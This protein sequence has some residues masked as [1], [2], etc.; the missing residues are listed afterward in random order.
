[1]TTVP[2]SAIESL[3]DV[4][5]GAPTADNM[6]PLCFRWDGE[7]LAVCYDRERVAG[8]TFSPSAPAT[9]LALGCVRE[10]VEVTATMRGLEPHWEPSAGLPDEDLVYGY[11]Y[12]ASPPA[13]GGDDSAPSRHTNR[14]PYSGKQI[15]ATLLSGIGDLVE[16]QARVVVFTDR[17]SIERVARCVRRASELRFRIREVHEWLAHSLRFSRASADAGDGL[18]VKTLGLPP[19]GPGFLRL[20]S[21]WN[22]MRALNAVG[23]YKLV[24]AIDSAPVKAA[25][26][27]VAVIGRTDPPG[28]CDAG[29][30]LH[31]A[32]CALNDGGLA[33]HPYYVI[34]DQLNRHRDGGIPEQLEGAARS[35]ADEAGALFGLGEGET[36][37]MLFRTGWPKRAAV[38]SQR[39]PLSRILSR[40]PPG[41]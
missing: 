3:V 21:D 8:H 38:R 41:G 39:L 23:G 15:P 24:S 5:R 37:H 25:P 1:M 18:D 17:S 12:F 26:A 31:R 30:L 34:G 40:V 6:Q 29:R 14:G 35:L 7:H 36:L 11:W 4:A 28:A 13:T 19:G 9:L 2:D 22:R 27:L 10:L 33:V 32:W 20:I 16:N